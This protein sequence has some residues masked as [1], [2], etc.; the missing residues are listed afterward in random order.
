MEL[1][2]T[3][4]VIGCLG[5]SCCV[6]LCVSF[7][8]INPHLCSSVSLHL[9]NIIAKLASLTKKKTKKHFCYILV[10]A[11]AKTAGQ[12]RRPLGSNCSALRLWS[13]ETSRAGIEQIKDGV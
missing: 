2:P 9:K 6:M 7:P 8:W 1:L 10:N 3:G 13:L 11:C 4:S 5:I 12:T